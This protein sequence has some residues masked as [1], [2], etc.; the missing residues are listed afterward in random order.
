[1]HVISKR[2]IIE[3]SK[4]HPNA[5][6]PL[7]NW[8]KIVDSTDFSSFIEIQRVFPTADKVVKFTVFNVGGNNYRLIAAIHY[9][10]NKLYIRNILTHSEYDK[11]KWKED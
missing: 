3:F 6:A 8:F 1:M 7:E 11:G 10:R 4:V 2:K 9:N 5:K